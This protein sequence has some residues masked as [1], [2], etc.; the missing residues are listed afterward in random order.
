MCKVSLI[1]PTEK[2]NQI[3][4]ERFSIFQ[5]VSGL[6]SFQWGG[7]DKPAV[8]MTEPDASWWRYIPQ[9]T[10]AEQDE[11]QTSSGQ[12]QDLKWMLMLLHVCWMCK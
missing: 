9:E 12:K 10:Q 7:S 2:F 3:Q 1:E 5:L 11:K 4:T 6:N 8:C